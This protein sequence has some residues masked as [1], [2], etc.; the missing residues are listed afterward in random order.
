MESRDEQGNPLKDEDTEEPL[1]DPVSV[2]AYGIWADP[3]Y[4]EDLE[5]K[6]IEEYDDDEVEGED[7][8]PEMDEEEGEDDEGE[9]EGEG[10]DED[11]K[12]GGKAEWE[13]E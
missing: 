12:E 2:T 3:E 6:N 1:Y 11:E 7:Y 13:E 8:E 5:K 9:G 10:E 4:K